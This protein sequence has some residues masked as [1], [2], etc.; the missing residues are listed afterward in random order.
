MNKEQYG[1]SPSC[2][3][4]E[5]FR[6]SSSVILFDIFQYLMSYVFFYV[7]LPGVTSRGLFRFYLKYICVSYLAT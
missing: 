1:Q 4:L 2:S 7:C 3:L 6:E 5:E